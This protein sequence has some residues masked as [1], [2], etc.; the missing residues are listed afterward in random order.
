M[1]TAKFPECPLCVSLSAPTLLIAH[2]ISNTRFL[3][4]NGIFFILEVAI[5]KTISQTFIQM[6]DSCDTVWRTRYKW[7]FLIET[8]EKSS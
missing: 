8:S 7:K 2:P 4:T 1:S 5:C 3:L 6:G